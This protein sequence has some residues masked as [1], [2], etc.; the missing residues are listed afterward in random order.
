MG[1]EKFLMDFIL[2]GILI[3]SKDDETCS[4]LTLFHNT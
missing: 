4:S 3:P 2:I 1:K